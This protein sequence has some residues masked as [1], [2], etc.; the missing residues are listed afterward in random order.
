MLPLVRLT[1]MVLFCTA[2][3]PLL[4]QGS[5][6]ISPIHARSAQDL[7]REVIDNELHD[8]ERDSHWEYRSECISSAGNLVREQIET[9]QGP[10]FRVVEEDGAP[11]DGV[12]SDR[13]E[14]RLE[15]YIH[16]PRQI[17][18]VEREHTEDEARLASIMQLLPKAFVFDFRGPTDNGLAQVAFRP[19]PAFIPS[20]YEARIVHALAGTLIIDPSKKRMVDIKG[21]LSE[22]VDFGFGLLG[23]L[24]KD[25]SFEIHRRQVSAGHWKTDLVEIHVQGKLL[26]LKTV[27]KDQREVRSNFRPIPSGLTLSKA[28]QMLISPAERDTSAQLVPAGARK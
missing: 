21:V 2:G 9:D 8:R 12:Q 15:R 13:E 1:T 26:I 7:V 5:E 18:R 14:T 25:G 3:L 17:A 19:D 20:S 10:V 6:A 16:N 11:L 27:S 4:A 24:E 23:Y 22:R 28:R